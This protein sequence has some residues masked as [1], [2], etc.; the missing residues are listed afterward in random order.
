MRSVSLSSRF[1]FACLLAFGVIPALAPCCAQ[2]ANSPAKSDASAPAKPPADRASTPLD[3][4]RAVLKAAEQE[5]P[6]D[7]I[8]MARALA[9]VAIMESAYEKATDHTL[10]EAQRAVAI[11]EK[12]KGKESTDYAFTLA[13]EARVHSD[14]D[15]PDLARPLADQALAIALRTGSPPDEMAHI[16]SS[17]NIACYRQDDLDCAVHT[18][19]LQVELARKTQTEAPTYMASALNSLAT[20][21]RRKGDLPAM[22]KVLDE[23]LALEAKQANLNDPIWVTTENTANLYYSAMHRYDKAREHL[24]KAIELS[25]QQRGP[26]DLDQSVMIANL[27]LAEMNLGNFAEGY[28]N[29]IKA[30]DMYV[31]EF[32]PAHSRTAEVDY[33]FAETLHFLGRDKEAIEWAL[34]AHRAKREYI[35]LAIRLMPERQALSLAKQGTPS[36]GAAVTLAVNHPEF[37][38]HDVYQEVVRSRS[39]VTEEMA[40]RA[41]GLSRKH[42]PAVDQLEKELEEDRRAVMNL[43][44]AGNKSSAALSDATARMD[45]AEQELAQRSVAF[46]TDERERSSDVSDLRANLPANTIL[47]SYLKYER[48]PSPPDPFNAGNVQSYAAFVM[49]PDGRPVIAYHLGQ[50]KDISA[51]VERMRA[52]ADAEAHGGGMNSTRNEREYREAGEQLRKLIWDPLLREIGSASTV[53]VVPDGVLNLVPFSALPRDMGYLADHG[54]LVHILT[55][56][57]DLLPAVHGQKKVGLLAVGSPSFE[58]AGI[59]A[60]LPPG[61]S[62]D[63]RGGNVK[64]DAFNKM[65]FQPLPGALG[66]VKDVFTTWQRWNA[67]ERSQMLTG[68]DATRAR[69][70]DAATQSRVLHIATH[71]FV[72]DQEC[73]NGNPLLHSGLVF[74]GANK[75]RDASVLTAQ[76]IASLDLDGVD[77]AVLSACNSGYGELKDGEGVLGLE[78]SFRVA[79]ARSVVMALW[80]VDDASTRVFMRAL[81]A[82]RYGHR[83]GS[84]DAVWNASRKILAQ[85]RAAG[86]STH[87][88]Y[89]AS[90]VSAGS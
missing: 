82:E 65:E 10:E 36:L 73:G 88:W 57:R 30:H 44:G 41:A 85:R 83:S 90:F 28:K 72:L 46:R 77:W 16:L 49:H 51:L 68:D 14:M 74:A 8:E 34:N 64:C 89:W 81:Y 37:A 59:A 38:V 39:L 63:L 22:E 43:E 12:V 62:D 54:P 19:E 18:A 80:P 79:G 86:K 23:L 71:A 78:R 53:F 69:F 40:M 31:R 87:P 61:H 17:L 75:A 25:V 67:H 42:D 5:H 66:E 35:T 45:K 6:G 56:E 13:I 26:D 21:L 84:A 24:L 3:D 20:N 55:S 76:Q 47:I 29:Y 60:P 7:S 50:S 4:A 15:R 9:R 32:G 70:I 11:A 48:I 27:A 58:L 1:G 33:R 52:S 2:Q